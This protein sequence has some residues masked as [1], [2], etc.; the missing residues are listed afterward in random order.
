MGILRKI[1]ERPLR[2]LGAEILPHWELPQYAEDYVHAECLRKI[3]DSKAIDCVFDVGANNGYSGNFLRKK[4]GF[5]GTI[6]SFEPLPE[7]FKELKEA[8]HNDKHWHAFDF[9]LG[10]QSGELEMNVMNTSS[11]SSFLTPSSATPENMTSRNI[12]KTTINTRIERLA[13][14]YNDLATKY[15]FTRPF[16]KMDTQ[17]F[18][19]EVLKGALP[20]INHFLGLQS[21]VSV[22]HIYEGM[23]DWRQS[24]SEYEKAGFALSDL[25]LVSGDGKLHAVEF[26]AVM[27]RN[28]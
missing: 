13:D 15:G 4:V 7:L 25:F 28:D 11:F 26:D 27:V 16:L 21:E 14:C 6:L 9:A 20:K 17:G 3:F 8:S 10:A 1:I 18:D 2:S 24:I 22:I 19:L 12:V 23:P 5:T